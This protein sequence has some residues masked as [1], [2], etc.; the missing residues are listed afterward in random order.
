M[1]NGL[2]FY[3]PTY[4]LVKVL[5]NK[6]KTDPKGRFEFLAAPTGLFACRNCR[7][8]SPHVR[9]KL[10]LA[11]FHQLSCRTVPVQIRGADSKTKNDPK[12][13]IYF[14][15]PN[16]IRTGVLALKG[17]CPRP[18]DDGAKTAEMPANYNR[19][20]ILCQG[21]YAGIVRLCYMIG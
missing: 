13:V 5:E 1:Q 6:Q 14:G 11:R 21:F 18:L 17:R 15:S 16:R 19:H 10:R 7:C 12:V 2:C 8:C 20:F 9:F 3:Y 4:E